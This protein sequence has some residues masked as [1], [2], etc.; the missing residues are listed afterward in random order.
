LVERQGFCVDPAEV[1]NA[2]EADDSLI[3]LHLHGPVTCSMVEAVRIPRAVYHHWRDLLESPRLLDFPRSWDYDVVPYIQ[4]MIDLMAE[5][6]IALLL[7]E[8]A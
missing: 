5:H 4:R 7:A 2:L 8:S 6:E 1:R 3:E